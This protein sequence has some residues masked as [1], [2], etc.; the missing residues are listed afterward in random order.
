MS[1]APKLTVITTERRKNRS[2]EVPFGFAPQRASDMDEFN[3]LVAKAS[4]SLDRHTEAADDLT[5]KLVEK[6]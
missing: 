2:G 4:A 5:Q 6:G 1:E 3:A